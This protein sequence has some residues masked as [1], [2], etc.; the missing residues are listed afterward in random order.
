MDFPPTR[1]TRAGLLA[2]TGVALVLGHKG[3]RTPKSRA[4][5]TVSLLAEHGAHRTELP[6]RRGVLRIVKSHSGRTEWPS[7]GD[8]ATRPHVHVARSS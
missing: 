1:P 4:S 6:V 8:A 2:C 3:W 7:L 5:N